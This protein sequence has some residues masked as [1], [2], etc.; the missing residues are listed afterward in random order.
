MN[1]LWIIFCVAALAV[2]ELAQGQDAGGGDTSG[3]GGGGA[4][5]E[6]TGPA[7]D[8]GAP[9]SG[10]GTPSTIT[11]SPTSGGEG[12]TSPLPS[13]TGAT[14]P[15]GNSALGAGVPSGAVGS[16][17]APAPSFNILGGGNFAP[18][19]VAGGSGRF[20]QPP[21]R[22]NVTVAQGYD[23]NVFS[24]TGKDIVIPAVVQKV[25]TFEVET[26]RQQVGFRFNLP[27]HNIVPVYS[28]QRRIVP[29]TREV[30]L[31]PRLVL[32]QPRLGSAVTNLRLGFQAQS[33]SPRTLFTFDA[34]FG[35]LYYFS[36][37]GDSTDLSGSVGLTY[38]HRLTP[39]LT[40]TAQVDAVSQ[41]QPDFSRINGPS[42]QSTGGNVISASSKLDLA[43][44][45]S[46]RTTAVA[47]YSFNTTIQ[48]GT[49]TG[50]SDGSQ[51]TFYQNTISAQF[52]YMVTPRTT[53]VVELR[54]GR[55]TYPEAV[56][57]DSTGSFLLMGADVNLTSRLRATGRV[58]EELRSYDAGQTASSPY[59]ESTVALILIHGSTLQWNNRFGFEEGSTI[60][61]R[62][63]SFRTNLSLLQAI[64]A[65]LTANIGIAYNH[66]NIS[67]LQNNPGTQQIVEQQLQANIGL[68]YVLT[69][70]FSLNLDY[71][72]TDL[73]STAP[74]SGYRRSQVFFG[75]TYTF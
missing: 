55:T 36:R 11:P 63:L 60:G 34:T 38:V 57:Q 19:T 53:L 52:R 21:F 26:T 64:N 65:H 45:V 6:P 74:N 23:D 41:S 8:A 40:V 25:T 50:G 17:G 4:G 58:G 10:G 14:P 28:T 48:P 56:G 62:R 59:F 9:D 32:K 70:T 20:A 1:R 46:R 66:I 18:R 15:T 22:F 35:A 47:S 7:P 30:E 27:F 71:S 12:T 61:Q 43:Y 13:S 33:I 39:R 75:A 68:R 72:L 5:A 2:S 67:S 37:P 44:Q 29:R 3:G 24:S 42:R 73:V 69:R 16:A 51:G 49:S 54:E 31:S